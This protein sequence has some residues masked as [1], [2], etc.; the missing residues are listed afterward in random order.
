MISRL[1][2]LDQ[3]SCFTCIVS[4]HF[5]ALLLASA[6]FLLLH[7]APTS[8]SWHQQTNSRFSSP[9]LQPMGIKEQTLAFSLLHFTLMVSSYSAAP[10][11]H[12]MCIK[13]LLCPHALH[14]LLRRFSLHFA[15]KDRRAIEGPV[16][17]PVLC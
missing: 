15:L 12:P 17:F 3:Y 5:S 8:P 4:F 2:V 10:P 13:A 1:K 16:A 6:A 7:F 14:Q 11:L 9:A